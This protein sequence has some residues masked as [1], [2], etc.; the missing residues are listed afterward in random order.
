MKVGSWICCA[1]FCLGMG[2]AARAG[3]QSISF[4]NL[5]ALQV[6]TPVPGSTHVPG[7]FNGDGVSDLLWFNPTSSEMAYWLMATDVGTV[8]RTDYRIF[9]ITPG[10]FVAAVGD[11]D[12]DGLADVLFTSAN[13]DLYL[14]TNNGKGGFSSRFLYTYPDGWLPV[15]AGDL[16]GDGQADLLWL[17]PSKCEFGYWLMKNGIRNGIRT[18]P[19]ACGY[20]PL[21]IGYYTPSNRISIIWTSAAHDLYAW[22]ST[23]RMDNSFDTYSLGHYSSG[24][25]VAFGGGFAGADLGVVSW[26]QQDLSP[27]DVAV[28]GGESLS[29]VFDASFNQVFYSD[30]TVWEGGV[31]LPWSSAGF[32]I[33]GNGVDKTGVIYQDG[34]TKI[35]ACPPIGDPNL[36]QDGP[37]P[38]PSECSPFTFPQG[39][40]VIGALFNG[41]VPK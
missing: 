38:L 25:L 12:G 16:D 27:P 8:S 32:V 11:F 36:N 23:G 5:P 34:G 26:Y 19:I 24:T 9:H 7:D 10:Y 33:E 21:S 22:D 29:R 13:H 39:W 15:G 40:Y 4:G 14:W 17:N 30:A 1:M 31:V 28:G 2:A 6:T 41:V 3:A 18:I 20:Y 35:E 37:A